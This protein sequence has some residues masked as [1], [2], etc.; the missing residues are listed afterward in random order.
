[1]AILAPATPFERPARL[2]EAPRF[3]PAAV[4]EQ[5]HDEY[6]ETVTAEMPPIAPAAPAPVPFPPPL[7][8]APAPSPPLPS[9]EDL[10]PPPEGIGAK[11]L[12]AMIRA[13]AEV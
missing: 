7:F 9:P 13:G 3:V 11:F 5:Q 10:G 6:P 4:G 12:A 1:A 2:S 8:V